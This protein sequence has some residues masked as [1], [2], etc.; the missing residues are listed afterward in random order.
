MKVIRRTVVLVFLFSALA[1]CREA[2]S[3]GHGHGHEQASQSVTL[4]TNKTEL[5]MEYETLVAG[6]ASSFLAHLTDLSDFQPIREGRLT[7][8]FRGTSG[9]VSLF[10]AD[11][12][13]RE[14]IFRPAATLVEPGDYSLDLVLES[15]QVSDRVPVGTVTV[16][17]HE[18]EPDHGEHVEDIGLITF[19]KEQQWKVDFRTEDV[20]EHDLIRTVRVVGEIRPKFQYQARVTSPV[21]GIVLPEQDPAIPAPGTEVGKGRVLVSIAPPPDA[22]GGWAALKRDYDRARIEY[23][24]ARR[25]YEKMAISEKQYQEAVWEY[26]IRKTSYDGLV[27]EL[28]RRDVDMDTGHFRLRSPIPGV[29]TSVDFVPCEK[30]SAGDELFQIVNPAK[31]WLVARVPEKDVGRIGDAP[32]AS[33]EPVGFGKMVVLDESNSRLMSISDVI[34][35]HTRTVDVI[36]EVDNAERALKVGQFARVALHTEDSFRDLAV[37]ESAVYDEGGWDAV[38]VQREGESFEKRMV[39]TGVRFQGWVQIVEG[40]SP[41]ERIVTVGGYQVKLAS[42][43]AAPGHGHTH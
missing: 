34:D 35:P 29:V 19:L 33:F 15:P 39:K 8:E 14:G 11:A 36:F 12:P 31:V 16:Y 9:K 22:E 24:R 41:G 32:G 2:P 7:L 28:G 1:G 43:T 10:V 3:G 27:G 26:E 25:L 5:F 18:Q 17:G 30:V 13:L 4:W 38:Y 6:H 20:Q 37:P 23:E 40:L 21:E 42:M